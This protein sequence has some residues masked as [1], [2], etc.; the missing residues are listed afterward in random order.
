LI[1]NATIPPVSSTAIA[2]S[3]QTF[4]LRDMSVPR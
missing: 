3:T 2:T 1:R 4:D